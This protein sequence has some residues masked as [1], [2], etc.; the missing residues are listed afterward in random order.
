[1]F[2]PVCNCYR[3]ILHSLLRLWRL[4][5]GVLLHHFWSSLSTPT[6]S[7]EFLISIRGRKWHKTPA[8]SG[9]CHETEV[10]L[11][12]Q[13]NTRCQYKMQKR[14]AG[15][16]VQRLSSISSGSTQPP[17]R[18]ATRMQHRDTRSHTAFLP[19]ARSAS[20]CCRPHWQLHRCSSF[21]SLTIAT[22]NY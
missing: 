8:L 10:H 9:K 14:S 13:P 4:T 6:L 22:I 17:R 1:M 12:V 3:K 18:S 19:G 16:N 7:S 5:R 15:Q 2:K 20:Q 11:P 21:R